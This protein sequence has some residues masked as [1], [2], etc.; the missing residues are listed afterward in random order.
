M[1]RIVFSNVRIY[2][3]VLT[4]LT[5]IMA[6]SV[7]AQVVTIG[8]T[9]GTSAAQRNKIRM[10]VNGGGNFQVRY[11]GAN[12][13]FDS[14]T[15]T[16]G[17]DSGVPG[18]LQGIIISIGNK[19]WSFGSL[20]NEYTS[21]VAPATINGFTWGGD[22]M[23]NASGT[24]TSAVLTGSSGSIQ[25]YTMTHNI[26]KGGKTYV[27]TVEYEYAGVGTEVVATYSV[28]APVNNTEVIKVVHAWDSYLTPSDSGP[29]KY[30]GTRGV[31]G[32][33][34][35]VS[36]GCNSYQGFEY[37]SGTQ[38][39]GHYS[40]YYKVFHNPLANDM[41]FDGSHS[42]G[43]VNTNSSTDNG[44]GISIDFGTPAGTTVQSVNKLIFAPNKS[45]PTLTTPATAGNSCPGTDVTEA[46]L[47]TLVSSSTSLVKFYTNAT[48]SASDEVV[49]PITAN[50]TVYAAN[51][52]NGC[53]FDVSTPIS[54]QLVTCCAAAADAP[55]FN[56]TTVLTDCS[57]GNKADLTALTATNQPSGTI[58]TWHTSTP[59]SNANRI[60]NPVAV[61]SGTYYAAFYDATNDCY[62]TSGP[63]LITVVENNCAAGTIDCNRVILVKPTGVNTNQY[64]L[65]VPVNVTTIGCFD[66]TGVSGAGM[67]LPYNISTTC[68]N[69]TGN[70]QLSI[71]LNYDGTTPLSATNLNFTIG[72][73]SC[74]LPITT[75]TN[76]QG[77]FNYFSRENCAPQQVAPTLK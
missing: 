68:T 54:V 3:M 12:Q 72:G 57:N 50:T 10:K 74:V 51:S 13:I 69:K 23:D 7:S 59:A 46:D 17:P 76:K 30:E 20:G 25:T 19:Y 5:M 75:A 53:V 41:T 45:A 49:Y 39:S 73:T 15:D 62:N 14:Q 24:S 56:S 26:T 63:S 27:F 55:V 35:S 38:W 48:P 66:I 33:T 70:Q 2:S 4:F 67:S 9:G 42:G 6:M 64:T 44:V 32:E 65:L 11:R 1:M 21:D 16:P 40:A 34:V 31:P 36:R 29:G 77:I 60:M 61:N 28:Q 47:K 52:L 8:G 37:V 18:T 58:L 71:P 43:I 22:V